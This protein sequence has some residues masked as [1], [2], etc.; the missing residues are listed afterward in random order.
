MFVLTKV[1]YIDELPD[2]AL[3]FYPGLRLAQEIHWRVLPGG[4]FC[5]SPQNTV[6]ARAKM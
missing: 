4:W 6:N 1:Y 2:A 5:Q 3:T